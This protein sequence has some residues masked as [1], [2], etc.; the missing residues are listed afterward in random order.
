[1]QTPSIDWRQPWL[2]PWRDSGQ[3]VAQA[4][5]AGASL[6]AALNREQTAQQR[7]AQ[8]PNDIEIP[9]AAAHAGCSGIEFVPQ[10][11][12]PPGQGYEHYMAQTGQCPTRENLHDFFNGLCWLRFPQIKRKINQLHAAEL[13]LAGAGATPPPR[14]P[15]RDALTVLDENAAFLLA[16]PPLWQALEARDWPRLFIE[17]RP[18]W[19]DAQLVL[20]GHAL[21]EK[22]VSPR[23]PITAHVYQ[24]QPALQSLEA[25]DAWVAADLS[26]AR[27]AAK[28]FVPLPV[29]GVPGWW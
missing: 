18:L 24:A 28:P 7:M 1:M 17:L 21:L 2:A 27:L 3:R 8:A 26:A 4:V 23:K 22:L 11:A 6:P 25:L 12:L 10:S 13:E 15:V 16:P 9:H 29:L 5:A 20:F 19:A 14:G